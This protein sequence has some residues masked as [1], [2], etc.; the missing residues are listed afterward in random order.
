MLCFYENILK[1]VTISSCR[2]RFCNAMTDLRQK[3]NGMATPAD[4]KRFQ[5]EIKSFENFNKGVSHIG[6]FTF[7][8]ILLLLLVIAMWELHA[9]KE[10]VN[11]ALVIGTALYILYA[12][13]TLLLIG[14]KYIHK[15]GSFL[16]PTLAII[17]LYFIEMHYGHLNFELLESYGSYNFM[18]IVVAGLIVVPC[19][20]WIKYQFDE[21]YFNY[22]AS[23]IQ[24]LKDQFDS[25]AVWVVFPISEESKYPSGIPD[26]IKTI[27]RKNLSV[28]EKSRKIDEYYILE[29]RK[30]IEEHC[31]KFFFKLKFNELRS[32][33]KRKHEV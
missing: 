31:V 28:E 15:T 29:I 23:K 26:N 1:H 2:T 21:W 17:S 18:V 16:I 32:F 33:M 10:C 8:Y 30:I 13:L 3:F 24:E 14:S 27:L 4:E 19:M 11:T 6:K 9:A 20:F 12:L 5:S 7:C 22:E 25:Y